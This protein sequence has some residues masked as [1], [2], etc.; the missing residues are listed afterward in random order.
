MVVSIGQAVLCCDSLSRYPSL[1]LCLLQESGMTLTQVVRGYGSAL[2]KAAAA[3]DTAL[4]QLLHP[5]A[6]AHKAVFFSLAAWVMVTYDQATA[7]LLHSVPL[8]LAVTAP[9]ALNML[10]PKLVSCYLVLALGWVRV[11]ELKGAERGRCPLHSTCW[12]QS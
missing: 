4:D 2:T 8:V 11:G 10:D 12:T 1:F 9:I 6:D 3:G 7:R 5:P